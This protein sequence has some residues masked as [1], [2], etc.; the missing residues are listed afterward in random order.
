MEDQTGNGVGATS[1]PTN[2]EKIHG[3]PWS[4]AFDISTSIFGQLS[5]F[6]S[7]WV[8]FLAQVG[9]SKTQIGFLLSL[10]L[11]SDVL[12]LFVSPS[13]ARA[14]YKRTFLTFW[15]VR[16][17]F[18]LF[19]F[20][21]P[22]V[23]TNF[24]PQVVFIQIS[25]IIGAF[26]LCRSIGNTALFPW[27]HE[28]IPHI[29]R[30]KYTAIDNI[31]IN[32][33]NILTILAVSIVLGKAPSL[34]RFM[35]LFAAGV[36]FGLL[37]VWMASHIPG[38]AAQPQLI[39]Q[40]IRLI[41]RISPIQ[42]KSL[43]IYLCGASLILLTNGTITSFVPLYMQEKIGLTPDWVV[44]IQIST[45]IGGLAAG[46]LWGWAADRYGSKPIVIT[47]VCLIALQP[48]FWLIIPRASSISLF[49]SLC[50]SLFQ[51]IANMG[52][53][54]GSARLL[55]VNVVPAGQRTE[56][57]AV[58]NTWIGIISGISQLLGGQ[59]L[60]IANSLSGKVWIFQVDSYSF[61]FLLGII[62][63]LLGSVILNMIK[64]E[65]AVSTRDF[66]RMLISGN[67]FLALESVIRYQFVK[68][69]R[70]TVNITAR[71]GSTQSPFT[72]EELLESLEDPRFNVRFEAIISIARRE[73]D[74]RLT[75]ALI[76]ILNANQPAL[77]VA[78]AWALGR[79]GDKEA[80]QPLRIGLKSRYRSVQDHTARALGTLGDKESI[81]ILLDRLKSETDPGLQVA[82]A[83]TLGKFRVVNAIPILLKM[84]SDFEEK[85]LRMEISL[86]L[87]RIIGDEYDFIRIMRQMKFDP[88]SA[89]SGVLDQVSRNLSLRND[90]NLD[91]INQI[92]HCRDIWAYEHYEDG[93]DEFLNLLNSDIFSEMG[94]DID[95]S[96]I[97]KIF[98]QIIQN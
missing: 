46:F 13:V 41:D 95:F 10:V 35:Y 81:P 37:S 79:I 7:M 4:V 3:L 49:C 22:W 78:A 55:F 18:I 94:K 23:V 60:D 77:S 9:L 71:L 98:I 50:V 8:L 5:F 40:R 52:W 65:D 2:I 45:M 14:G 11:F 62:L 33:G 17:I 26:S 15:A 19:I 59:I 84:L 31:S 89:V 86:A 83:S 28:Y 96:N 70:S 64:E 61:L 43:L 48:V 51:G 38:G 69:E 57:M 54:I 32:I 42:D 27:Q 47:G 68:D 72:V 91:F 97:F 39:G 74:P 36:V 16:Y 58:Y 44:I 6:G 90:S 12:A 75:N 82:Y 73:S 85:E 93:L 56:Y 20:A 30:G 63:P 67:P 76:K 24:D 1:E 53:T 21:T 87:A 88:G 80:I 92:N 25:I 66:A 29:I 34:E